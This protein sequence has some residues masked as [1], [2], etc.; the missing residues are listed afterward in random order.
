MARLPLVDPDDP[1]ADPA[2]RS[3]LSAIRA[4]LDRNDDLPW[5]DINVYSAMANHPKALGALLGFGNVVYSANALT[6]AQR[7]LAYLGASVANDCHY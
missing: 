3:M 7:E 4:N 2:A 1:D 5:H 6:P